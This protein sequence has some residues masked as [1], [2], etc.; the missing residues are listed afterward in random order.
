MEELAHHGYTFS[1]GTLYPILQPLEKA[2]YLRSEKQIHAG[3]Q[4][5]YYH[6]TPEGETALAEVRVR[7]KELV[8]EV[9]DVDR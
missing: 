7:L 3:K 5:R 4:H 8:Q 6:I 2:G 9:L 1:P